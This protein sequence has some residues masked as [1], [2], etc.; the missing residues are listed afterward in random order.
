[1]DH[2]RDLLLINE[3]QDPHDVRRAVGS[4]NENS[5][6]ADFI[7]SLNSLGAE[8]IRVLAAIGLSED[9]IQQHPVHY[10]GP[11]NLAG[12]ASRGLHIDN[13]PAFETVIAAIETN[14]P[15]LAGKAS[16]APCG[17]QQGIAKTF[18][19]SDRNDAG[20]G[21]IG[22]PHIEFRVHQLGVKLAVAALNRLANGLNFTQ[23]RNG[24]TRKQ[25]RRHVPPV[26]VDGTNHPVG[27]NAWRNSGDTTVFDQNVSI[28]DHSRLGLGVHGSVSDQQVLCPGQ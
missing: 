11:S 26:G 23:S 28:L 6:L 10:P 24:N 3:C 27:R 18:Y 8:Q 16:I 4:E 5:V 19:S 7:Q 9:L 20:V 15:T 13:R 2:A 22:D 17:G 21:V 25:C 12:R 1:M 14:K